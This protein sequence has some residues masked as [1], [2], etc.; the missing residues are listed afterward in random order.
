MHVSPLHAM[1]EGLT[2]VGVDAH[3]RYA[4]EKLAEIQGMSYP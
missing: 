4:W 1:T 2:W 3:P